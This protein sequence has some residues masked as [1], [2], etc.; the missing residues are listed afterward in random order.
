MTNKL[1]EKMQHEYNSII[2]NFGGLTKME[3]EGRGSGWKFYS[4]LILGN[5]NSFREQ[6]SDIENFKEVYTILQKDL[7]GMVNEVA[8]YYRFPKI[9]LAEI[10]NEVENYEKLFKLKLEEA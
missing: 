7:A 8:D 10:V 9:E 6:F 5:V 3:L 2:N 4:G 1:V